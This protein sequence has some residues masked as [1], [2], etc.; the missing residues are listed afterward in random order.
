MSFCGVLTFSVER[1]ES[2][3]LE[4]SDS[5]PNGMKNPPA[6]QSVSD[7]NGIGTDSKLTVILAILVYV[8]IAGVSRT[9][10]L[11]GGQV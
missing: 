8:D 4:K 11:V 7:Q 1:G 3:V 9:N 2:Q 10:S 6:S 5:I